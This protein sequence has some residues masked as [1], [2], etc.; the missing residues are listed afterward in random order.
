MGKWSNSRARFRATAGRDYQSVARAIDSVCDQGNDLI[1]GFSSCPKPRYNAGMMSPRS[2]TFLLVGAALFA[3]GTQQDPKAVEIAQSMMQAMGGQDAW[4]ATH[5]LRFD[6]KV[7]IGGETKAD[8]SH[9]WDKQTGRYRLDQK[10]QVVLMNL[11]DKK[12]AAY[13]DGKK[14]EGP[15]AAKA[16]ESAYGAY[17]N[18]FYWLA[19]PWKWM[20]PGVNLKYLG[21]KPQG[22]AVE[23]TFGKVGLTPGD[24]Y[25]AF[26]SPKSH[27]M[28][29]WEYT[30]QS[31]TKGSWDWQY[32]DHGGVKLASNHTS[33][34][35]KRIDMGDVRILKD[36]DSAYFTDAL[37]R[38]SELK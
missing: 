18:D 5:Y 13:V 38:L 6:F 8:R 2:A 25:Q 14:L 34:P 21:R 35:D 23:L 28:T 9:L 4:N 37:R 7:S 11:A 10:N 31:G 20:D 15:D 27:L 24:R 12:G 1:S 22:D 19:M 29:H 33:P 36:V 17:I 26:V 16:L 32:G 30:L 3:E